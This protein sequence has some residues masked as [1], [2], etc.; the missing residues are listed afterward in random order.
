MYEVRTSQVLIN[1]GGPGAGGPSQ[2]DKGMFGQQNL[3]MKLAGNR[4]DSSRCSLSRAQMENCNLCFVT[5]A[6]VVVPADKAFVVV[7]LAAA[8]AVFVDTAAAV[9]CS[10]WL[11]L[12]SCVPP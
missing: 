5:S 11:I 2:I 7:A 9:C 10:S 6:L 4:L 1:G 8:F 3:S 12:L